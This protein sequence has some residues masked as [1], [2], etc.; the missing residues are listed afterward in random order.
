MSI[1]YGDFYLTRTPND[2]PVEPGNMILDKDNDILFIDDDVYHRHA[3]GGNSGGGGGSNS[4]LFT[5]RRNIINLGEDGEVIDTNET[6]Y[7]SVGFNSCWDIDSLG[8]AGGVNSWRA[9]FNPY[10]IPTYGLVTNSIVTHSSIP[11]NGIRDSV[12]FNA[13]NITTS[14]NDSIISSFIFGQ[15]NSD[16]PFINGF[17]GIYGCSIVAPYG[18]N[19]SGQYYCYGSDAFLFGTNGDSS[20][21][22]FN[23]A[24]IHLNQIQTNS[25]NIGGFYSDVTLMNCEINNCSPSSSR[26]FAE[27][28]HINFMDTIGPLYSDVFIYGGNVTT[29]SMGPFHSFINFTASEVYTE[30]SISEDNLMFIST[31]MKGTYFGRNPM[32]YLV[33]TNGDGST[34]ERSTISLQGGNFIGSHFTDSIVMGSWNYFTNAHFDESRIFGYNLTFTNCSVDDANILG[35][36]IQA[37]SGSYSTIIGTDIGSTNA[38]LTNSVI[39][40]LNHH[41]AETIIE[42]G[43]TVPYTQPQ[44]LIGGPTRQN[45]TDR[46]ALAESRLPESGTSTVLPHEILRYT[47]EE[48]MILDSNG[49]IT[50]NY[51]GNSTNISALAAGVAQIGDINT[52]LTSI[53]G[54]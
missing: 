9:I 2:I 42:D 31:N 46:V 48:E 52:I 17:S 54:A 33:N 10:N 12:V 50:F 41:P 4:D 14:S 21:I 28:S 34:I 53:V 22:S 15:A 3:I 40:G 37:K 39:V 45:T 25:S 13:G 47:K 38:D 27:G 43:Q 8:N 29:N 23:H 20:N 1:S 16:R 5:E 32:V 7:N 44:V 26:I 35:N 30:R 19:M 36:N 6:L 11:Q 49:N 51:N 24:K 18:S